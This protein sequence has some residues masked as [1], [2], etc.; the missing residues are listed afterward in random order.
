MTCN[1]CKKRHKCVK[2][3]YSVKKKLSKIHVSRR[4]LPLRDKELNYLLED[5][6]RANSAYYEDRHT[7][8]IHE[9]HRRLERLTARERTIIELRYFE[10]LSF[11][12]IAH[13]LCIRK[14]TA[15]ERLE[16]ALEKMRSNQPGNAEKEANF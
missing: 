4:E 1:E 16:K 5:H 11:K 9:L 15:H 10:G 3:C 12:A 2:I 13:R 8:Y 7:Q 14:Q 6:L